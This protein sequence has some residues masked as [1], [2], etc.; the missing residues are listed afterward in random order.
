MHHTN[1]VF[2]SPNNPVW[3]APACTT[4]G[5][6]Q[7][8]PLPEVPRIECGWLRDDG[9]ST[10]THLWNIVV[11]DYLDREL[12]GGMIGLQAYDERQ[13]RALLNHLNAQNRS[14][15][16]SENFGVA[17]ARGGS[18]WTRLSGCL[19]EHETLDYTVVNT[20][21]TV[22][23][24]K[25]LCAAARVPHQ[26]LP[27]TEQ[28]RRRTRHTGSQ[29]PP[30]LAPH[31]PRLHPPRCTRVP[32]EDYDAY[33]FCSVI[34]PGLPLSA[35]IPQFLLMKTG[36]PAQLFYEHVASDGQKAATFGARGAVVVP[37]RERVCSV[38]AVS[39][40]LFLGNNKQLHV[41]SVQEALGDRFVQFA[42]GAAQLSDTSSDERIDILGVVVVGGGLAAAVLAGLNTL[43]RDYPATVS[44]TVNTLSSVAIIFIN[45]VIYQRGFDY[46]ESELRRRE[47]AR[48]DTAK[49]QRNN[50]H[51]R[52][53]GLS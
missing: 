21:L 16:C 39:A 51:A 37:G 49:E 1:D 20:D 36:R 4:F 12:E 41:C 30:C 11:P 27:P 32:G 34:E 45:K 19:E 47:R 18:S 17:F 40:A 42:S 6:D 5:L 44:L 43:A 23:D 52:S 7:G 14:L 28:R 33:A 8:N 15:A 2:S 22:A 24:C 25:K 9:N 29:K 48:G 31:A 50:V 26:G 46:G 10:P 38:E 13:P 53:Q 3:T 35:P